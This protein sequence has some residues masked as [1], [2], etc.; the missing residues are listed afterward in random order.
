MC[1]C[2]HR[3]ISVSFFLNVLLLILIL[4]VKPL[5]RL[6]SQPLTFGGETRREELA[7]AV[8]PQTVVTCC[9]KATC[10]CCF[11]M[12]HILQTQELWEIMTAAAGQMTLVIF[13]SFSISISSFSPTS[14]DP[15]PLP[16][17]YFFYSPPISSV[18]TS[19]SD[20][21]TSPSVPQF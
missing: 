12:L 18:E 21:L 10:C 5:V 20:S 1:L 14:P 16:S 4:T 8:C 17:L 11:C 6:H 2:P 15:L 3:L 19:C 7:V 13:S 9:L